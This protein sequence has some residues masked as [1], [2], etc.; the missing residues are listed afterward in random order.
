MAVSQHTRF[1]TLSEFQ[2]LLRQPGN[3]ERLIELINGESVDKVP[4]YAHGLIAGNFITGLNIFL[5]AHPIGT[6]SV[7]ARYELPSDEQDPDKP[8]S[9]IPD[10][11]YISDERGL[12]LITK[13]AVPAMPDLAFEVQSPDQSDADMDERAAYYLANGV[14]MVI[15]V[16]PSRLVIEK[17]TAD[18]TTR[19]TLEDVIDFSPVVPGFTMSV[20]EIFGRAA[21]K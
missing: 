15:L 14:Q 18:D 9:R 7:E 2:A 11:S 19:Y 21:A 1:Y 10:V 13:G 6:A 20:R 16:Y 8:N 4:T 5:R 12:P 3:E 17:R